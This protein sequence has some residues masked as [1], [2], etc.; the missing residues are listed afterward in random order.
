MMD[1]TAVFED[2][3]RPI[4][5]AGLVSFVEPGSALTPDLP[6]PSS[7]SRR[8]TPALPGHARPEPA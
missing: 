6:T 3:V 4:A 5:E 7:W 8:R 1:V 2:S